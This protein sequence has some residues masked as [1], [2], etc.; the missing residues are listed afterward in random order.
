MESATVSTSFWSY[1]ILF[2][3]LQKKGVDVKIVH[4]LMKDWEFCVNNVRNRTKRKEGA[5][6]PKWDEIK[7]KRFILYKNHFRFN[8][9][10]GKAYIEYPDTYSLEDKHLLMEKILCL[11]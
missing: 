8:S 3:L 5:K 11:K 1:A 10:L 7:D 2:D 4:L 9:L 6:E